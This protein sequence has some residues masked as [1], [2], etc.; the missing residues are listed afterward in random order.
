MRWGVVSTLSEPDPLVLAFAAHY[1]ALGAARLYLFL[2]RPNPQV[3]A[4]LAADPRCELVTCDAAYWAGQAQGRPFAQGQ[5]QVVNLQSAYDRAEEDWLLH[6]DADEFLIDADRVLGQLDGLAAVKES[7]HVGVAERLHVD[8]PDPDNVFAGVFR[9][10][11]GPDLAGEIARLDGAVT[12]YLRAGLAGY[13]SGKSFFRTGRGLAVGVHSPREAR[14]ERVAVVPGRPLLHFDGL[15]PKS[16]IWKKKRTI[17][18][19]PGW[20]NFPRPARVRQ[21]MEVH[22]LW[23]DPAGLERLYHDLKVLSPERMAGLQAYGLIRTAPFDPTAA[24]ARIFPGVAVDLSAAAYDSYEVGFI[25]HPP[26]PPRRRLRLA[27]Q[28]ISVRLREWARP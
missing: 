2:D 3:A 1:L 28:R 16:W 24:I 7:V 9:L 20:V 23:N 27:A 11:H 14:R 5:R 18:Q 22:R 17:S 6:V 26:L 10:P 15:T 25:P 4:S 21:F 12:P 13:P 19:Q 8:T